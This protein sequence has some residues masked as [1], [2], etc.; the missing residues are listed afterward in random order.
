MLLLLPW[1]SSSLLLTCV[2]GVDIACC[3]RYCC[4]WYF[5]VWWLSLFLLLCLLP[6]FR[7][8]LGT[9]LRLLLAVLVVVVVVGVC[10]R[11]AVVVSM[12]IVWRHV[13]CERRGSV[14]VCSWLF[15]LCFCRT[16]VLSIVVLGVAVVLLWR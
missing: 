8:V 7:L 10:W 1:S 14:V 15:L 2:V 4:R 12:I 16:A 13:V 11:G 6:L 5:N 9:T 3:L